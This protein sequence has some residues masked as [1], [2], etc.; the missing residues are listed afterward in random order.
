MEWK[1]LL[2]LTLTGS[3]CRVDPIKVTP[4]LHDF[5]ERIFADD[6]AIVELQQ[7]HPAHFQPLARCECAGQR[8]FGHAE[9]AA[10]PMPVIAVM[11]I[12]EAFKPFGQAGA[13]LVFA[14]IAVT[15]RDRARGM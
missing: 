11:H 13:H 6:P 8:P 14:E 1:S 3:G 15:S 2:A 12:R 10:D 4:L 7:I 5:P 9:I